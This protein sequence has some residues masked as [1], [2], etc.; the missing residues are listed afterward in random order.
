[1]PETT[2]S[3]FTFEVSEHYFYLKIVLVLIAM[4]KLLS[5]RQKTP[6]NLYYN[7]SNNHLLA[8]FVEKTQIA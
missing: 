4:C 1:M 5:I 3:F 8:E 7:R 6:L 2:S